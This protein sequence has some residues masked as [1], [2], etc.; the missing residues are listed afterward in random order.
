MTYKYKN[1]YYTIDKRPAPHN[2]YTLRIYDDVQTL[3][4]KPFKTKQIAVA[5]A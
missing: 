1:F 5:A 4:I 3:F 2:G